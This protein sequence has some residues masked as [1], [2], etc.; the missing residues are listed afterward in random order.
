[1]VRQELLTSSDDVELWM[2]SRYINLDGSAA[3]LVIPDHIAD[4]AAH[5]KSVFG[6]G[7]DPSLPST[8][9]PDV[10][11]GKPTVKAPSHWTGRP[12]SAKMQPLHAAVNDAGLP[13]T[14]YQRPR[15]AFTSKFS[16]D[17]T[18]LSHRAGATSLIGSQI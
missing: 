7:H 14:W 8:S 17:G 5:T 1:M 16:V 2:L 15:Y 12:Y 4:I 6:P 3:S 10:G 13:A 9:A 11:K 18:Y